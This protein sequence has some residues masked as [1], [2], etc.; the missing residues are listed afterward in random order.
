MSVEI[1][2]NGSSLSLCQYWPLQ[3]DGR[4]VYIVLSVY[5]AA[6][7]LL[8]MYCDLEGQTELILIARFWV[9]RDSMRKQSPLPPP[10]VALSRTWVVSLN[11][12]SFTGLLYFSRNLHTAG[13]GI[14]TAH[15][16]NANTVAIRL[17]IWKVRGKSFFMK[18]MQCGVNS[19]TIFDLI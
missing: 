7:V 12:R 17:I 4:P 6:S 14:K 18:G 19:K 10:S 1:E 15:T 13:S 8:S 9:I 16:L 5:L 11:G 2:M 3:T